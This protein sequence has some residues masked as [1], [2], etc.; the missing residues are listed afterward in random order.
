MADSSV[1]FPIV[2]GTEFSTRTNAA[3]EEMQVVVLGVDGSNGLVPSSLND[4]L[5]TFDAT[6]RAKVDTLH[7]DLTT[8]VASLAS[9][10][11]S[12]DGL[13]GNTNGLAQ[14]TT[15]AAAKGVLDSIL[16]SVSG[17]AQQAT[18]A[19]ILAK[20]TDPST[21][22][23]QVAQKTTLDAQKT[24]LDAQKTVLDSIFA[25]VDQL[26]GY[27]DGLETALAAIRDRLPLTAANQLAV[28]PYAGGNWSYIA[29]TS[30]VRSLA[31][32]QRVTS[33]SCIGS[34]GSGS[35]TINGG[36]SIAIPAFNS[37]S[38]DIKGRLFGPTL[39]FVNTASYAVEVIQ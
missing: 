13:E 1:Q 19:S 37:F 38:L 11:A 29:G 8:A 18:L 15:L 26:E 36:E 5:A 23:N 21:A 25:S 9:I 10:L 35:L 28:D 3:G 2:T 16:V 22:A 14:Q 30:G 27:T 32:N 39:N 17:V 33:I 34:S 7:A 24:T 4:G 31:S 20:L 12:V 6:L